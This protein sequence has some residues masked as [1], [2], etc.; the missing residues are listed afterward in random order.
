MT[1]TQKTPDTTK[2]IY[3]SSCPICSREVNSYKRYSQDHGLALEYQDLNDTD[4]A[5]LNLTADQAARKLHVVKDGQVIDGLDAFVILWAQMPRFAWL[6]KLVSLPLIR[7]IANW[8]Y[9]AFLAPI[10]YGMH[11]RRQRKAP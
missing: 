9:D 5:S 4:L 6:A 7:P 3:N 11:K 10:L 8:V 1:S 2:V